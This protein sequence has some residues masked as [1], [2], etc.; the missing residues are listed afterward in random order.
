MSIILASMGDPTLTRPLPRGGDRRGIEVKE[1]WRY[2]G[3]QAQYVRFKAPLPPLSKGG[4]GDGEGFGAAIAVPYTDE[5]RYIVKNM[6]KTLYI[7][8]HSPPNI[9]TKAI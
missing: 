3:S 2:S 7:S 1:S 4:R 8:S 5:K 6:F 9:S